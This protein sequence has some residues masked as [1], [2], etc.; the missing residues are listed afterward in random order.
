M[1]PQQRRYLRRMRKA[2]T[3]ME[4]KLSWHLRHRLPVNGSHFRRQVQIGSYIAD[5]ACHRLKLVIEIDGGQ[6]GARMTQDQN[7]TR[8][9]AA[10]G[11][12]VLLFWN[13]DV[14]LN[15]DGVL[16]G[17]LSA[18]TTTPTPDHSPQGGGETRVRRG[19]PASDASLS[20]G[21]LSPNRRAALLPGFGAGQCDSRFWGPGHAARPDAARSRPAGDGEGLCPVGAGL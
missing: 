4:R 12:R 20:P 21:P 10:D 14:L 7:R 5:F 19:F 18:L 13:N 2:P 15:I 11:Y 8:R 16:T 17:I 6:H 9:L 1:A 3:E